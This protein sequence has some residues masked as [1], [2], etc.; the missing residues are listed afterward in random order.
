MVVARDGNRQVLSAVDAVAA[1]QG[2]AAGMTLTQARAMR[3][4]LA[5]HPADPAGDAAVLERLAAWCLRH[6][7]LVSVDPPDGVWIDITGC[8]HLSGGESRLLRD[9]L[10]GVADQGLAARAAVADTPGAAWA[11]ARF[12]TTDRPAACIPPAAQADR[13]APLPVEA[14][15]LPDET[16]AALRLMGL[17]T[18]GALA[19]RPR[20]PLVRRFGATL[21]SRLDQ[22]L[23]AVFTP[24]TPLTPPALVQA[25]AVFAEPL[26]GA[27]ALAAA[28]ARL[29]GQ[30]CQALERA[31]LGVR[32]LD[33]LFERVDGAVPTIR[34]GTSRPNRDASHL[35]RM[36]R[37]RMERIDPGLG[38]EAMRLVA[39]EVER[40]VPGTG[41]LL[42]GGP[43]A[44][45]PAALT[46]RLLNR[47]GAQA[48]YGVAVAES[49][50]PERSVRRLPPGQ[51]QAGDWPAGAPRPVRLLAEPNP[52]EA[53]ALLPDHPPVAFTWRRVRHRVRQAEGPERI[54]GEWW[55]R[56]GEVR[57]VRDYY[58]VE[59]EAGRR[60]WLFRRG[61][62]TDPGTGDG[63]W[64][65]HGFF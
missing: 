37:E 29:A 45:P 50:V 24:I 41:G 56:D 7:P 9:L 40:L 8:A 27:E 33:L 2:L 25:R 54:A 42:A 65:L 3:P 43:A 31:E 18:I 17:D 13:L 60:F 19:D 35:A 39:V 6:A 10:R 23:G 47:F 55:R 20:A 1:D 58:R 28:L 49:Y 46:D 22:A 52:I 61:D 44:C 12:L 21:L 59:D 30:V 32:R 63:R 48:V 36:L 14:L 16:A 5:V 34:I 4:G 53:M 64:F 57:S 38:I 62:G 51:P 11:A 26:L 15:R